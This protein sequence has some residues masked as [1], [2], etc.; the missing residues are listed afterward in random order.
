[1]SIDPLIISLGV[2]MFSKNGEVRRPHSDI[3]NKMCEL[4]RLVLEAR[5]VDSGIK[6][7]KDSKF[8]KVLQAVTTMTAFDE[9]NNTFLTPST[10][11][12]L[13]HW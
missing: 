6:N 3:Q 13:Q 2:R 4:A 10:A 7:L 8:N 11:L 9:L 1:M 5:K 12:K